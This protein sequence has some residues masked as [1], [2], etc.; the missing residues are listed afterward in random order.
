VPIEDL[1]GIRRDYPSEGLEISDVAPD[2]F[3]TFAGWF[4]DH[5]VIAG[6]DANA[7][8]LSTSDPTTGRPSA[9]TVLLRGVDDGRFVFF[10][11]FASRKGR[12]L[13]AN[14]QATLLF[15][16]VAITRQ[17]VVEGSVEQVPDTESDAYFASRPRDSQI[18]AWASQQSRPI[19]TREVLDAAVREVEERFDGG[20]VPR[21][22]HWGGFALVPDRFEFWQGRPSRLHDRIEYRPEGSGWSRRRLSP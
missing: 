3:E 21:P 5:A 4:A 2:P 16:W 12:E 13:E 6:D 1:S 9:R 19:E 17:I 20:A 10:T 18:G 14:P 15:A 7:V 22:P 11:N 8:I